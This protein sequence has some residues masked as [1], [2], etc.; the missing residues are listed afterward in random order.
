MIHYEEAFLCS[1]CDSTL[2]S[3]NPKSAWETNTDDLD[4]VSC[5]IIHMMYFSGITEIKRQ[6]DSKWWSLPNILSSKYVETIF[7]C[8]YESFQ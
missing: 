6:Q 3:M 5:K 4:F 1:Y 2:K 8:H 7:K